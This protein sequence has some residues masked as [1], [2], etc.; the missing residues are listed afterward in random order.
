MSQ[1]NLHSRITTESIRR[2]NRGE[3]TQASTQHEKTAPNTERRDASSWGHENRSIDADRRR[4]LTEGHRPTGARAA[5]DDAVATK[6][7]HELRAAADEETARG[8]TGLQHLRLWIVRA[9]DAHPLT[10]GAVPALLS[11]VG[12]PAVARRLLVEPVNGPEPAASPAPL[13]RDGRGGWWR[14][15]LDATAGGGASQRDS[16]NKN[17]SRDHD[18]TL[19][20]PLRGNK[21][22]FSWPQNAGC[23][24]YG[25]CG[26]DPR[27][28]LRWSPSPAWVV[29]ALQEA[30]KPR[31]SG[32][33]SSARP[34]RF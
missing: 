14:R 30:S 18:V 4:G 1:R 32:R 7:G 20:L 15:G 9:G 28:S 13:G 8:W 24:L 27:D 10:I 25:A 2:R 33:H 3:L 19:V 31:R 5:L 23:G 17:R 11:D 16:K 12:R 6:D 22:R 26:I 29:T 21:P 34:R